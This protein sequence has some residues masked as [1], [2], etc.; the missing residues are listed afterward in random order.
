MKK[1]AL[2]LL[3]LLPLFWASFAS[4]QT[5]F[6]ATITVDSL[7][8]NTTDDGQCTLREAIQNANDDL[9]TFDDCV[10]GTGADIIDFSVSGTINFTTASSIFVTDAD[11][12]VIDGGGNIVLDGG[13]S[14]SG[15]RHFDVTGVLTLD[16]ITLQNG[17]NSGSGGSISTN[18]TSDLTIVN[19]RIVG[20]TSDNNGGALLVGG[21]LTVTDSVFQNN[22]ADVDGGAIHFSASSP[23]NIT[24][25]AFIGNTAGNDSGNIDG[26]GGAIWHN[27]AT[28]GPSDITGGY[29]FNNQVLNAESSDGGG[30]I[31]H[32][33][34]GILAITAS[35][36]FGNSASGD[37]ARGGA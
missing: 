24:N 36:F 3:V 32:G 20:N 23:M 11:G 34:A 35:A 13:G 18:F 37:D 28:S 2:I 31:Y 16:N 33:T 26:S 30:A 21:A 22:A 10:A 19:T 12:L 1:F 17:Y 5:A 9:L 4:P 6:G 27:G 25:V 29:F 14:P 15:T 8:D 7:A